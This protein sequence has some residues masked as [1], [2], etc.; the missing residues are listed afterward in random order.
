MVG[1]DLILGLASDQG[2][3]STVVQLSLPLIVSRPLLDSA[4]NPQ[5]RSFWSKVELFH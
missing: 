1:Q 3:S 4:G 5:E 2:F